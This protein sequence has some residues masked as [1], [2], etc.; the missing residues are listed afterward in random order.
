MNTD[1]PF[2][3]MAEQ[4]PHS[5]SINNTTPSLDEDN[6]ILYSHPDFYVVLDQMPLTKGHVLIITRSHYSILA[7]V[8]ARVSASIA[9]ILPTLSRVMSQVT[10]VSDSNVIQNNGERASQTVPHYHIH[11]IPRPSDGTWGMF[12][13][14]KFGHGRSE[15]DS[16]TDEVKQLKRDIRHAFWGESKHGLWNGEKEIPNVKSTIEHVRGPLAKL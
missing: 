9:A 14:S 6:P 5:Q 11:F 16:W 15:L 7:Q 12:G 4:Y 1:C 3:S 2:C 13:K 8:P 10:G